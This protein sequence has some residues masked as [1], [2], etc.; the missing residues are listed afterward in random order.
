MNKLTE[1]QFHQVFDLL[2]GFAGAKE[3]DRKS[4]LIYLTKKTES[5][6]EWRFMGLFGM[7]GKLFL[8]GGKV[9]VDY[10]WENQT[11]KLDA[12]RDSLNEKIAQIMRGPDESLGI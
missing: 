1:E 11:P 6:H 2:V 12:L 3:R 5:G 7:G 10:Y 9:F 8:Y 4:A